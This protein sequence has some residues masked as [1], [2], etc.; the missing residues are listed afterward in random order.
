MGQTEG[1]VDGAAGK[2]R[3]A[4]AKAQNWSLTDRLAWLK[5]LDSL[6]ALEKETILKTVAQDKGVSEHQVLLNEYMVVRLICGYYLRNAG[7][8][9]GDED[10]SRPFSLN[11]GN[12]KVV[13]KKEPLGVVAIITP[14]NYPFSIPMVSAISALLAGNAVL[15]KT[16]SEMTKSRTLINGLIKASLMNFG[17]ADLFEVVVGAGAAVGEALAKCP[18]VDKIHFT[19]STSVGRR[20]AQLNSETR[21]TPPTLELGGSNAAIVLEDANLKQAARVVVWGRFCGM[22][23]NN[24]KR[25]FVVASVYESFCKEV[26]N[27]TRQLASEEAP[28]ASAKEAENYNRFLRDYAVLVQKTDLVQGLGPRILRVPEPGENLLVLREETFVPLLP[29]VKVKDENEAIQLANQ[30]RFGLGASV[31]TGSKARFNSV[32][33]RLECGGVFHNDA[34]AEYA[35]A[36]VP[37]G[38]WKQSGSG[39]SHGPEGLLEL[40]RLKTVITE[41]WS[42]PKLQL[43][44][45]TKNKMNWLRKL[46]DLIVRLS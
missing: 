23:C 36:Q 14:C 17:V 1:Q 28:S 32:A 18:L 30:S 42:A 11:F 9:L 12:K 26:E 27:Q 37:F 33:S 45:W 13:V 7:R 41:R 35:Q 6:I 8:I 44:P 21:F 40:V 25:V 43:Y 4:L 34:M 2:V 10:R 29:I 22:S 31:F 15:L 16:A 38:G 19:G 46:A 3:L 39:Y 5:K 24:I 20:L